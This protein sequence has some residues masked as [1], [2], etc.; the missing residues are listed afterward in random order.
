MEFDPDTVV[1]RIMAEVRVDMRNDVRT[2]Q[3][4][5]SI[6]R[7]LG[8]SAQELSDRWCIGRKQAEDHPSN[9]SN[10]HSIR[11]H[12]AKSAVSR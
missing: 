5:V 7:H 2:R 1:D 4:F 10:G 12:A 11:H 6:E 9:N 8:V 3:T